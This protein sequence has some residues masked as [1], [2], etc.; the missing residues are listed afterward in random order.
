MTWH[1]PRDIVSLSPGSAGA[2]HKHHKLN[3]NNE[4]LNN[5]TYSCNKRT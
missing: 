1:D 4:D 3:G 5:G 2:G